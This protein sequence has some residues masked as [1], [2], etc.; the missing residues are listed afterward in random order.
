MPSPFIGKRGFY[1]TAAVK[2]IL[3]KKCIHAS[4][5]LVGPLSKQ[6]SAFCAAA[7]VKSQLAMGSKSRRAS[8]HACGHPREK[9][10]M[11]GQICLSQR[12][13]MTSLLIHPRQE[14]VCPTL[15][16][17]TTRT[18]ARLTWR[19]HSKAMRSAQRWVL[20]SQMG[21]EQCGQVTGGRE[22]AFHGQR[23]GSLDPFPGYCALSHLRWHSK[24]TTQWV[25][26]P[27][28]FSYTSENNTV[29]QSLAFSTA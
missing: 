20:S 16:R 28:M 11:F 26:L 6:S 4:I 19:F 8:G 21:H 29:G 15:R 17:R 5:P 18:L 10:P 27:R 23:N 12:C 25:T 3:S 9:R 1:T 2:R 24:D 14:T 22:K 7:E 13:C